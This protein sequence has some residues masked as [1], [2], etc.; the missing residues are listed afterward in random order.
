MAPRQGDEGGDVLS[1]LVAARDEG[2]N[3]ATDEVRDALMTLLVAG[4]E[5]TATA[6]AWALE[7]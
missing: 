7:R 2:A 6:L 4:H 1:L 3:R 5:T